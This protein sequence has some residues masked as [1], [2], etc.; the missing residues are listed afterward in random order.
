MSEEHNKFLHIPPA[1]RK[2]LPSEIVDLNEHCEVRLVRFYI[3]NEKAAPV[4]PYLGVSKLSCRL[5]WSFL[6]NLQDP[7]LPGQ[8]P[9]IEFN[10]RG[11]DGKVDGGWL[12]PDDIMAN[13]ETLDRVFQSLHSVSLEIQTR[14]QQRLKSWVCLPLGGD[15]FGWSSGENSDSTDQPPSDEDEF[16]GN[17]FPPT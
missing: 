9:P 7:K 6:K 17:V 3:E 11:E 1:V 13:G 15:F 14:L 5:C 10:V 4:M 16:W 2:S 8:S 12:P